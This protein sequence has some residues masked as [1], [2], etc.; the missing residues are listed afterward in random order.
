MSTSAIYWEQ[1]ARRF[2]SSGEGLAAVCA[3]GMPDFYNRMIQRT[4]R[5]ALAPWLQVSAGTRV[6]DIGCGVGR[7]SRLLA[8]RGARVTGIDLS[9]T[10][11]ET[12]RH[13][14]RRT[15]LEER[16]QFA[17]GDVA[18]LALGERYDLVLAVTVLQH[19][20]EPARLREAVLR[21][22]AHLTPSGGAVL[23]EAAPL[24]AR[25]RCNSAVFVARER[26]E[27]LA[28]FER[29]GLAI[30]ALGAVD[31]APFKLWLLPYLR[32][33]PRALGHMALAAAC[34]A[35]WPIDRMGGRWALERSWH[36][37]FA[38]KLAQAS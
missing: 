1:R 14:A 16:C 27:Y 9:P 19:I 17:L 33:A 20:L 29:C 30:S 34:A 35:S 36:T 10:M 7:W 26:S 8:S 4:Q 13:G 3:Y 32:R 15:G 23:L 11:I 25:P 22:A 38:L 28:L 24:H 31:P 5:R 6:L 21:I 37:V 12:A 18:S 2:A